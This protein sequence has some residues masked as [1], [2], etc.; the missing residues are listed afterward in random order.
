MRYRCVFGISVTL[1]LSLLASCATLTDAPADAPM[2]EDVARA[3]E[4][5]TDA[6]AAAEPAPT[7]DSQEPAPE[8]A[9]A[10][11]RPPASTDRSFEMAAG[12]SFR[13][14]G[15]VDLDEFVR[16]LGAD[17][18]LLIEIRKDVPQSRAEAEIYLARLKDLAEQSDP[19]RLVP[20]ANRILDQSPIYFDWLAAEYE[21]EEDQ[22]R[23]YYIGGA[24]GFRFTMDE[25]RSA[26][27]LLIV[28]RM[29]I[30][31]RVILELETEILRSIE[32]EE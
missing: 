19:V 30:A 3:P 26:V 18:R 2:A 9:P 4:S 15:S 7:A 11:P 16:S 23:E 5:A 12:I 8:A 14:L 27:L 13:S 20:L 29:E 10:E 6:P 17:R 24:Q 28:N 32:Q 25:F 31:A 22:Q 1:G 21:S